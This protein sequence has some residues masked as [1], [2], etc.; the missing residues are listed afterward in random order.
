MPWPEGTIWI[1]WHEHR[2]TS[3]LIDALGGMPAFVFDDHRPLQRNLVGPLWTLRVLWREK[4]R[5]L[6]V[7]FSYLLLLVC[8]VYRLLPGRP[9]PRIVCDCHNKALKKELAGPLARPFAAFKRR[10]LGGADLLVVTNERLVPYAERH[11]GAVAVLRDPLTDWR[12]EDEACRA[13]P[14]RDGERPYVFFVCSF[15]SDEPV[16]LVFTAARDIVSTL[17][18]DVVVSGDPAR[19]AVP[20][21][22]SG[23]PRIRLPGY[24]PLAEYRRVLSRAEAVVVLTEDDD[25]LVC[26]AYE[27]AGAARGT[28]LS[29]TRAL[30]DCFAGCAVYTAHRGDDLLEAVAVARAATLDPEALAHAKSGFETAFGRELSAFTERVRGLA[31]EGAP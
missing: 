28:V 9:R 5:L 4:P 29:D 3:S 15:D 20:A 13:E 30:R 25:C 12:G 27:A 16:D 6:F 23:D 19:V 22:V 11:N 18:L 8:M 17:G 21:D 31:G 7:H 24:M 10:L 26:G 14:A 2:R 1:T